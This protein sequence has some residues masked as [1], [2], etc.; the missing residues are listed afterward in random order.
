[1]PA[2]VPPMRDIQHCIDLIPEASLPNLP[3]Y[4]M[5]P[6][7]NEILQEQVEEL[8]KKVHLR[9]SISPCAM[10]ALLLPKKDS[11]WR[12]CMDS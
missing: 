5:S 7:E 1:M 12:M 10:P 6:K 8:L 3:H 11:S 2:L 4:R 9:E